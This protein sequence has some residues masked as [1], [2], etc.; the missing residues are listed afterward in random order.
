MTFSQFA[1]VMHTYC[2]EDETEAAFV[3]HLID[4]IMGGQPGR[5]HRDGTYQNPMRGKD[6]RT[7]LNYYN[8]TRSISKK[9]AST[10]Y[11]SIKTE[12]FEKYIERRCSDD[13]K[14]RL[15]DELLE[16][17]DIEKNLMLPQICAQLF[18]KILRDLAE[19]KAE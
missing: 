5:A 16:K 9:D 11:S 3:I 19:S 18:E 8:G 17:E 7:L 15:L 10:I 14:S 1:K 2:N 6:N 12:K 4:E 13:A